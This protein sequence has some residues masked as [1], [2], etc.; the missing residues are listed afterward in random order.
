MANREESNL[1]KYKE[2]LAWQVIMWGHLWRKCPSDQIQLQLH[3]DALQD[4]KNRI[5]IT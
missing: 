5:Y 2:M 1:F 3:N 4:Y